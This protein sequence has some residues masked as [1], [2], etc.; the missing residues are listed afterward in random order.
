M[1]PRGAFMLV[2]MSCGKKC[3]FGDNFTKKSQFI[4]L[5]ISGFSPVGLKNIQDIHRKNNTNKNFPKGYSKA[6]KMA[7]FD[8]KSE[9]F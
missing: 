9:F 3:L 8:L 5:F 6:S 1:G 4:Q 2:S 7:I